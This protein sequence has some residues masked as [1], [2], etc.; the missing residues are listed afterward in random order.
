MVDGAATGV[1]HGEAVDNEQI[2]MSNVVKLASLDRW[3]ATW[4]ELGA[5][6]QKADA[7]N[8]DRKQTILQAFYE[9]QKTLYY[10]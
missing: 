3:V 10:L 5:L 6:R 2:V 7:L 1:P 9:I 8:L 4:T